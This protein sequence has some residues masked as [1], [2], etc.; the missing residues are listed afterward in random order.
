MSLP[1]ID[2][3]QHNLDTLTR[4]IS[5]LYADLKAEA[6]VVKVIPAIGTT[7][8]FH[9]IQMILHSYRNNMHH[10][11]EADKNCPDCG[12]PF[13]TELKQMVCTECQRIRSKGL[14]FKVKSEQSDD[15][16]Q[17][18]NN[19]TKHY[20][21]TIR[22]IYGAPPKT[23]PKLPPDAIVE[24][25]RQLE[26]RGYC[27]PK[28]TH[29]VAALL[30]AIKAIG[31]ITTGGKTYSLQTNYK[32]H[33]NHLLTQLYPQL[34]APELSIE[35]MSM[36]KATFTNISAVSQ[37]LFPGQYSNCYMY[38]IFKIIYMNM[39]QKRHARELLRYIFIQQPT[40]FDEKDKKLEAINAR[41]KAFDPFIYTD[42]NI[43]GDEKFYHPEPV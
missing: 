14:K 22:R 7:E 15:V 3:F 39:P 20:E 17:Y 29:Y 31:C 42:P 21:E 16:K 9:Q 19:I 41:I 13:T 30:I 12:I 27:I 5:A 34:T 23:G 1:A 24:L 26:L 18:R 43:Y 35:E 2:S 36:L 10:Y 4:D 8:D 37:Q 32:D 40:S 33:I 25:R 6:D 38:T 11:N 28:A